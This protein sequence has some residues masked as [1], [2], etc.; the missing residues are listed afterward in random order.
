[1][2]SSSMSVCAEKRGPEGEVE[3]RMGRMGNGD[4]SDSLSRYRRREPD[5]QHPA[6]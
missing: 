4:V 6:Y 3:G 5:G 2:D 1:M